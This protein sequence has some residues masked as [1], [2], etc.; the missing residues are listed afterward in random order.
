[1]SQ[2]KCG[3]WKENVSK[4]STHFVYDMRI[5][6]TISGLICPPPPTPPRPSPTALTLKKQGTTIL[7]S[8]KCLIHAGL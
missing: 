7:E 5:A 4:Y 3:V 6:L 8:H 2:G 1:M